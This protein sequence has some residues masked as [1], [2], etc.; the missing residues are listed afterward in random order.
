MSE[1]DHLAIVSVN[2]FLQNLYFYATQRNDEYRQ[3]LLSDTLL[4]SV[5]S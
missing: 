5:S 1:H 3:H 2:A 4:V